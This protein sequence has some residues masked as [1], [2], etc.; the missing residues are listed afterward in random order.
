MN[1]KEILTFTVNVGSLM[2]SSGAEIYRVKETI[3][4]ILNGLAV[5]EFDV[6]VVSNGI[7]ASAH[8]NREDACSVIRNITK[9][10][11]HSGKISAINQLSRDIYNHDCDFEEAK[12]RFAQIE[13][14]PRTKY[15]YLLLFCGIGA[16]AFTYMFKGSLYDCLISFINGFILGYFLYKVKGSKFIRNIFG[17]FIVSG[18]A[19]IAAKLFP[20]LNYNAIIIG[21]LM[22]LVPGVALTTGVRD[23][24]HGDYLSGAIHMLDAFITGLCIAVG[25]GT[26]VSLI[27][28]MK[29]FGIW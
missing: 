27:A 6:Y 28:M 7:F 22:P 2:L 12:E 17:A 8:E 3:V 15:K 11:M 18:V 13:K 25:V 10:E 21:T 20:I 9:A 19:M 16:S 26:L 14:I 23:L 5:E 29:G 24:F 1:T 4:H